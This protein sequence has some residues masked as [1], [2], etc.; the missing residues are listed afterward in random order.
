MPTYF[1]LHY[2]ETFISGQHYFDVVVKMG[3]EYI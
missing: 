2:I 1:Q 3:C